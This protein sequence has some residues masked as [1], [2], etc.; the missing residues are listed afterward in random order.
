VRLQFA[1][2]EAPPDLERFGEAKVSGPVA[3][4][5]V[6]RTRIS[7]MLSVLLDRYTIIDMSVQDPPLD[8]VIARVFEEGKEEPAE[9]EAVHAAG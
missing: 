2:D 4:L 9:E 5:K 8:Q 1:G 6:D 7:E 3:E